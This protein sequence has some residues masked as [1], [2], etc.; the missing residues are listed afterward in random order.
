MRAISIIQ[1]I[2]EARSRYVPPDLTR[3]IQR[4]YDTFHTQNGDQKP[5]STSPD[6]KLKYDTIDKTHYHIKL[7]TDQ[8]PRRLNQFVK[9]FVK[10]VLKGTDF[11]YMGHTRQHLLTGE[12]R[13]GFVVSIATYKG[14]TRPVQKPRYLYHM[15]PLSFVDNILRRGL[16]PQR[17]PRDRD[18]DE[19]G[20][21]VY[22]MT[23]ESNWHEL[24]KI[25]LPGWDYNPD[26]FAVFRVDTRKFDKFNI[27]RDE[28]TIRETS[29]WTP[30]HIPS[31]ALDIV[32]EYEFGEEEYEY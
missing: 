11:H 26:G 2:K 13:P 19:Y 5:F 10:K 16:V 1:Q 28:T 25:G 22:L 31:Y 32:Y 6:M 23:Q 18:L 15:T 7:N 12:R 3:R 4:W 8:Y 29:V 20:S 30:T 27:F 21:R 9:E 14:R 24:V 17:G